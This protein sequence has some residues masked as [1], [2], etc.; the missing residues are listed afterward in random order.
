MLGGLLSATDECDGEWEYS[1]NVARKIGGGKKKTYMKFYGMSSSAAM[2]KYN[3]GVAEY[4]ASEGELK[5]IPYKGPVKDVIHE[6]LG[7][8]RSAC[9]YVGAKRLKDLSKR[10]TFVKVSRLK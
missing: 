5:R 9:A 10:T 3:G 4:R 6:I 8:V 7:G 2:N 1:S